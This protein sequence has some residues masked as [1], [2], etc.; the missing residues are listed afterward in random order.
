VQFDLDQ[1]SFF[2]E[3]VPLAI[4]G[5]LVDALLVNERLLQ[6]VD[7]PLQLATAS[8]QGRATGTRDMG[9]VM[10]DAEEA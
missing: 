4:V 2:A 8:L 6:S 5:R 7:S 9:Q 3:L 1:S 10:E